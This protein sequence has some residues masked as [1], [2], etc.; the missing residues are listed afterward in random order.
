MY[1]FL[2]NM[3]IMW[4]VNDEQLQIMVTKGKITTEE[5][6]TIISTPQV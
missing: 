2:L 6:Q 3:W 4:K 5:Y 1:D